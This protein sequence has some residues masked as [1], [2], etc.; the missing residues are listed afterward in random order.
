MSKTHAN[1]DC[2]A[3]GKNQEIKGEGTV[4]C[5]RQTRLLMSTPDWVGKNHD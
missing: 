2:R 1:K 3:K 5:Y 4:T